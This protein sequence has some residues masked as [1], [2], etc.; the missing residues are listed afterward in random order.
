MNTVNPKVFGALLMPAAGNHFLTLACGLNMA[1]DANQASLSPACDLG[2][3]KCFTANERTSALAVHSDS[4]LV[5]I[6][7]RMRQLVFAFVT[8]GE[9]DKGEAPRR[10]SNVLLMH[11]NRSP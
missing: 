9:C 10:W 11:A 6:L 3:N 5:Q 1:A 2:D 7:L 4:R 8:V